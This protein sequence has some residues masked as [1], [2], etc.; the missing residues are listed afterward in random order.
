MAEAKAGIYVIAPQFR[1]IP[2]LEAIRGV[3]WDRARESEATG[4]ARQSE[5]FVRGGAPT[6][7]FLPL[8]IV[9]AH[10]PPSTD[11]DVAVFGGILEF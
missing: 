3:P 11:A 5:G 4:D 6:R 7:E 8:P 9:K 2:H 10:S 1:Q